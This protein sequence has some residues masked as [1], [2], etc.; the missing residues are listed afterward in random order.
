MKIKDMDW[1]YTDQ[2][3]IM[4][5]LYILMFY[6]ITKQAVI[7]FGEEGKQ[8]IA[9]ACKE[10]GHYRGGL[11][12]IEQE[13]HG[14]E[15][16]V[17]NFYG[18]YDLPRDPRTKQKYI[19]LDKHTAEEEFYA[20]HFSNIWKWLDD[21][22]LQECSP[23]GKIYCDNFHP[24]M[25]QGYNTHMEMT[26]PKI[27]VQGDEKC[28]FI[29]KWIDNPTQTISCPFQDV[30]TLEWHYDDGLYVMNTIYSLLY[31]FLSRQ[32]IE[33]FS[34]KGINCTADALR[35]YGQYRG[36]LLAYIHAQTGHPISE[37]S[38]LKYFDYPAYIIK[39]DQ[40]K[41][42]PA[43]YSQHSKNIWMLLEKNYHCHYTQNPAVLYDTYMGQYMWNGYLHYHSDDI[44]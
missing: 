25:W 18:H 20:C 40:T 23:I 28:S 26:L 36:K 7:C 37:E 31:F 27:I 42:Y 41:S 3:S 39:R 35:T 16:N 9:D 1:N 11:L 8:C 5:N 44:R 30:K 22:P 15:R 4:E 13:S 19:H 12:A 10:Y 34:D 6:F 29:T 43:M 21:I 33:S 32:L 17:E 24:A 14:L 2:V 38:F